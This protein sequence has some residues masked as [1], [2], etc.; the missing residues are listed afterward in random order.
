MEKADEVLYTIKDNGIGIDMTYGN[1]VFVLFKRLENARKYEGTGV[2][3][4]IV[5]RILEKH[6]ARI[7]YESPTEGG[8]IF[9]LSF[10]K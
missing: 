5:K 10:K 7:W 8:T 1:Q 6:R 4:A 9:Y 2:G 3:L